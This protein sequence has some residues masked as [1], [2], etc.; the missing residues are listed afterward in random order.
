MTISDK[1]QDLVEIEKSLKRRLAY[2]L[3]TVKCMRLLLEPGSMDEIMPRILSI[4]HE[5]VKNSRSYIFKNED[6]PELGLCMSQIYEVVSEGIEPQIDN[7]NL[8]HLSYSEGAPTILPI[9]KSKQHFA[10]I[11]EELDGPEKTILAEQGILS[12]LIIPIFK[13]KDL[14]GFIGFD[15]CGEV[16]KWHDD[17][18]NL[19]EIVAYVIGESIN[20]R[21]A[22]DELRES[23]ERFKILHNATFGGILIHD[24][25]IILDCNQGLINM[26]GYSKEELIGKDGFIL[27]A[28]ESKA[29]IMDKLASK[30]EEPYEAIGRRKDGTEYPIRVQAKNLPHK[31]RQLRVTEIRDITEQKDSEKA[32]IESEE[33]F[34][35]LHKASFGGIFIHKDSIIIDCNLGLSEISGYSVEELLGMN[36]LLLVT[37]RCRDEIISNMQKGYEESFE[38]VGLRKDGTE[39]PVR[40]HGKK[41]PYK[42]KQIRS[43]E[44]RDITEQK[45][46]EQAIKESEAK[47]SAMIANIADVIAIID[48]NGINRYKSPNIEKWFG[49]KAEEIVGFST[50]ENIH[51][52]DLDHIQ[53]VFFSI[54]ERP[55]ATVTAESRYRCKDGSYKWI[56]F[57]VI[58]LLEETAIKGFLLN[59]H[60]ITE[61]KQAENALRESEAKQRAMITNSTDVIAIIDEKGMNRYKSPNVER[62]FGWKPEELVGNSVWDN[63]H[64]DDLEYTKEL[65][66][67]FLTIPGAMQTSESRYRCKDGSYKWIE[68]TISNLLY[69]PVINGVMLNYHD[70][71]ERKKTENSLRESERKFRNYIENAPY[72][73]FIVDQHGDYLEVNRTACKLTGYDEKELTGMNVIDLISPESL[74]KAGQSFDELKNIGFTSTELLFKHK[75]GTLNWVRRDATKLSDNRYIV[76]ASDITEK[77][78][79]EHSLIKGKILAEENSRIKSEF[80]ANMSHEL[81]TPL[82]TVIGFSDILGE[83]LAGNL[84]E[85]QLGYVNHINKSGR[86]L[87]EIINDILD[88]FKIESGKMELECE[89]F[90]VSDVLDEVKASMCPLAR[91]K[92]IQLKFI[93]EIENDNIYAD[94]M[95]FRQ[96]M[97]NL[98]SNAIKFTADEGKVSIIAKKIDDH[99]QVSVSDTGIGIPEDMQEDIF[100]PFTQVDASNKRK[101]G[102]TGLGLALVKQFVDMHHGKIWLKSEEGKGSTFTF[103][104]NNQNSN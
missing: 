48:K 49:W 90:P 72:G 80:L 2:E 16:R 68:Y 102:G 43:V 40:I 70:I 93:N 25:S 62:W 3:A 44:F 71:T 88:L 83:G 26:S 7:P 64:P 52:D 95:K 5:T 23:E 37:K 92:S 6:D 86:H 55:G 85:K 73:V 57:T 101:Y 60:D 17:D 10:H 103:T 28:E 77:K 66:P 82:T 81:R 22:E 87:L 32:L 58:N 19:L 8:Q 54:M 20:R 46:S 38:S 56:E 96:I 79:A 14:W 45:K 89:D 27:V 91:K 21:N 39:Y 51:P 15:D 78:K 11:I 61:R 59:Y 100:S 53:K 74:I 94:K 30:Y 67:M 69:E 76:F 36:G 84:S 50:W 29:I 42:G 104:I 4:I 31:G 99:I 97:L 75:D 35:T 65:F 24:K 34:K 63:I 13:G 1:T 18:M 47:L 9:L 41:I 33:R 12:I 98:L